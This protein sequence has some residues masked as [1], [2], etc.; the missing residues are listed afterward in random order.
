MTN[1][2]AMN[3]TELTAFNLKQEL[4]DIDASIEEQRNIAA[5]AE[6]ILELE[7]HPA[8]KLV[9]EDGYLTKEAE[10]L[11]EILVEPNPLKR[12]VIENIIEMTSAIRHFKTF[13][14]FK[15]LDASNVE[16]TI[17]QLNDL[18]ARVTAGEN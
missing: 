8:Y 16:N 10:R 17:E 7:A 11:T 13:L 4:A 3:E 6:A 18:R 1:N 14:K 15:K 5:F 9:I 2:E 12:D